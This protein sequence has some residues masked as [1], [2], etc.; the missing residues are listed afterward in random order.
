MK[1]YAPHTQTRTKS[2]TQYKRCPASVCVLVF[3]LLLSRCANRLQACKNE[4]NYESEYLCVL[5]GVLVLGY[6]S[7]CV[8][9]LLCCGVRQQTSTHTNNGHKHTSKHTTHTC[10]RW[11]CFLYVPRRKHTLK[12]QTHKWHVRQH[13]QLLTT[14]QKHVNTV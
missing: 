14:V 13:E 6:V 4:P 2:V 10:N 5:V 3:V 11:M 12:K 9:W 7:V 1:T 8:F